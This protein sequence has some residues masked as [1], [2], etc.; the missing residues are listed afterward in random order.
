[1]SCVVGSQMRLGSGMAVAVA[2]AINYSSD[3]TLAWEPPYASGVALN[4]QNNNNNNNNKN[5]ITPCYIQPTKLYFLQRSQRK[6]FI[7]SSLVHSLTNIYWAPTI[8]QARGLWHLHY[9]AKETA[10]AYVQL[11]NHGSAQ[12]TN[13]TAFSSSSIYCLS[14]NIENPSQSHLSPQKISSR[15]ILRDRWLACSSL[16]QRG[17]DAFQTGPTGSGPTQPALGC[18]EIRELLSAQ[19]LH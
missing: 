19:T 4:R 10:K 5:K 16:A 1:M 3:Q 2:Q 7:H 12:K 13:H 6:L 14:R 18:A 11:T 17:D 9:D 8:C 15:Y